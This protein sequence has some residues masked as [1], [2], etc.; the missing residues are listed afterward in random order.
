MIPKLYGLPKI[1]KLGPLKM[2]PV[3]SNINSPN[4]GIAKWLI[5]ETKTLKCPDGC[6]IKNSLEF[7]A[8]VKD[9]ILEDDEI[10]ISFDVV[11]LFPS[12]QVNDGLIA[13]D[14]LA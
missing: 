14:K 12:I 3:A 1:H 8:K 13:M 11:S 9:L 4:Y 5:A 7:A 2:R 6:S 10:M